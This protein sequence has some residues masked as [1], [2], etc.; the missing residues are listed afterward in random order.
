MEFKINFND[1]VSQKIDINILENC[2]ENIFTTIQDS[3]SFLNIKIQNNQVNS[4]YEIYII[5][6][7]TKEKVAEIL[8]NECINHRPLEVFNANEN[9]TKVDI[10]KILWQLINLIEKRIPK[11]ENVSGYDLICF[12]IREGYL[13]VERGKNFNLLKVE[14]KNYLNNK[15]NKSYH[16]NR[17]LLPTTKL[18]YNPEEAEKYWQELNS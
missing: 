5:N 12:Y 3:E 9:Y 15:N 16:F 10:A 2:R 13:P 7:K 11:E 18:K 6:K 14:L 4:S 17:N 1:I 8:S